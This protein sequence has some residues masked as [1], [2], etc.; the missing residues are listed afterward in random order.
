[1]VRLL[2]AFQDGTT[3]DEEFPSHELESIELM[4]KESE[5]SLLIRVEIE[6]HKGSILYQYKR[7]WT[8]TY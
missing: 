3:I 2:A 8:P 4:V 1:M 7:K 6:D 5:D